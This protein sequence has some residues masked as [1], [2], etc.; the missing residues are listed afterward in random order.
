MCTNSAYIQIQIQR[1]MTSARLELSYSLIFFL[2]IMP[3]GHFSLGN[4]LYSNFQTQS[5]LGSS[6]TRYLYPCSGRSPFGDGR[7]ALP[8]TFPCCAFPPS[9]TRLSTGHHHDHYGH[10]RRFHDTRF[11][12]NGVTML[13]GTLQVKLSC[14]FSWTSSC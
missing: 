1:L 8:R 10:Q 12:E 2:S 4:L 13:Y 5:S 11:D 14:C 9:D 3:L 7:Y 6:V